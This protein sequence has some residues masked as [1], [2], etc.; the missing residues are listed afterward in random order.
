MNFVNETKFIQLKEHKNPRQVDRLRS[1]G[2]EAPEASGRNLFYFKARN[3]VLRAVLDV[4]QVPRFSEKSP[5]LILWTHQPVGPP[6]RDHTDPRTHRPAGPSTR[7]SINQRAR[8]SANQQTC[9][10]TNPRTHIAKGLPHR[11]QTT[12][13]G[14]VFF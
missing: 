4:F 3:Q 9:G 10:S 2:R 6:A 7:G 12:P 5:T 14:C 13:L 11:S 8:H 1:P